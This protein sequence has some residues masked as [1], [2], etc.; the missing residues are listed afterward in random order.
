MVA[1][2]LVGERHVV[3]PGADVRVGAPRRHA[4]RL[5][6][7][8]DRLRP[9]PRRLV[10]EQRHRSDVAGPMALDAV[11]V[12]D[13]GDVLA[14]GHRAVGRG[15]CRERTVA[16]SVQASRAGAIDRIRR[17][18]C[19]FSSLLNDPRRWRR[20]RA[21]RRGTSDRL[22]G[23]R[24]ALGGA[25]GAAEEELALDA[26]LGRPLDHDAERHG[27]GGGGEHLGVDDRRLA[28]PLHVVEIHGEQRVP[29]HQ[30]EGAAFGVRHLEAEAHHAGGAEIALARGRGA[31]PSGGA[32]RSRS[33]PAP[34]ARRPSP[35]SRRSRPA[36]R[37]RCLHRSE[38]RRSGSDCAGWRRS[39]PS[40]H[41]PGGA[42]RPERPWARSS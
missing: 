4:P 36:S 8:A 13:R 41:R 20:R 9:R 32:A 21:A 14:V 17:S 3:G 24:R 40:A 25:H 39:C 5:D 19:P 26:A 28:F 10:V 37:R 31:R 33:A 12:E 23:H 6:H 16:A 27:V 42:C 15:E 1:T 34:G 11:G 2:L 22:P 29:L 18:P 35:R 38:G 7:L 30:V